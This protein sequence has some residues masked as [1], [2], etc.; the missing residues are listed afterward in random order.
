MEMIVNHG[1]HGVLHT[2]LILAHAFIHVLVQF[3][4]QGLD[5]EFG[6]GD[7]LSVVLDE[8]Q[9]TTL[10]SQFAIVVHIL[11]DNQGEGLIWL[12]KG[13]VG[14]V[15][16]KW[17]E[18]CVCRLSLLRLWSSH[19]KW[20]I[21][22]EDTS[23]SVV[24]TKKLF[25]RIRDQFRGC[26]VQTNLVEGLSLNPKPTRQLTP[27][28]LKWESMRPRPKESREGF[29]MSVLVWK[30]DNEI[31]CPFFVDQTSH[32][33]RVS[34]ILQTEKKEIK[35]VKSV[36]GIG[37]LYLNVIGSVF[38]QTRF[39]KYNRKIYDRLSSR[40]LPWHILQTNIKPS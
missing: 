24:G 26:R 4:A 18:E 21:S 30:S 40:Y 6:I 36:G 3:L 29:F 1:H 32:F 25:Y 11:E 31:Y 16:G 8:R 10:G 2:E 35:T 39:F 22:K 5:D 19:F 9:E 7:F 23:I 15:S 14:L 28:L 33:F 27:I 17:G 20:R 37:M 13:S 12:M 38:G 34:E